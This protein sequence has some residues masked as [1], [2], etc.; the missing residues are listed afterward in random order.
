MEIHTPLPETLNVKLVPEKKVT[1]SE[2]EFSNTE[3]EQL[4]TGV[5]I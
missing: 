3:Q 5:Q 1:I 4:G 2:T